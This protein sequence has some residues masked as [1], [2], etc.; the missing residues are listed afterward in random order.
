MTGDDGR[1]LRSVTAGRTVA[2][3]RAVDTAYIRRASIGPTLPAISLTPPHK[4]FTETSESAAMVPELNTRHARDDST[5]PGPD[6]SS[7][8]A[9]TGTYAE[10]DAL[11]FYDTEDP[12]AWLRSDR[13]YR[14]ADR[15]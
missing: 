11:V 13:T 7:A 14:L 9:R 4:A 15:R 2:S 1:W 6:A 10:G 5:R 8:V 12:L 3:K